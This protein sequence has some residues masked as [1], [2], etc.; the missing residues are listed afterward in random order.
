M[1]VFAYRKSYVHHTQMVLMVLVCAFFPSAAYAYTLQCM[2][3]LPVAGTEVFLVNN[4]N[5]FG[6]ANVFSGLNCNFQYILNEIIKRMYCGIQFQL[7]YTLAAGMILYII[8]YA[9]MFMLG[10]SS[11]TAKELVTRLIKMAM[12]WAFAMNAAWGVG[13]AFY[14][15]AGGIETVIGWALSAI[16]GTPSNG[17]GFFLILDNL[18]FA[19]LTGGLTSNGYALL[20]FFTT[21]MILMPP[22]FML[23]LAYMVTVLAAL[24]RAL[25]SYLLGLAAIAFLLSLGPIFVSLAL[26]KTTY[27][28]F[29]SWLKYMISFAMQI[30]LIF[31]ALALWIKVMMLFGDFFGELASHI[32]P[33]ERIHAEGAFAF[34]RNTWG[35][36]PSGRNAA[37]TNCIS[38][39]AWPPSAYANN[40]YFIFYLSAQ[41]LALGT[42]VYAF[43]A[44]LRAIPQLAQQLSG[45]KFAPQLGGGMPGTFGAVNMPGFSGINKM[46]QQLTGK[47]FSGLGGA[48]SKVQQ[49]A[50]LLTG[51]G[52]KSQSFY[53]RM[54][55]N[56]QGKRPA[57]NPAVAQ[58]QNAGLM[59]TQ[60]RNQI[61]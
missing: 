32:V 51:E 2:N 18:I 8:T 38:G 24:T 14:F 43:D 9:I 30:I 4:C 58:R 6:I 48:Y 50:G 10:L 25:I 17:Q 42:V 52:Q 16:T 22:V 26:F 47:A 12:I 15:F 34:F 41:L 23:F 60:N 57:N 45:P 36:C 44:L 40:M 3:G 7:A 37:G 46:Q 49:S 20:G 56:K 5:A 53:A 35:Y 13:M 11:L 31:A 21:L 55:A 59:A 33:Y 19:Q 54:N 28:F 29:D 27:T 39:L 61:V 1:N